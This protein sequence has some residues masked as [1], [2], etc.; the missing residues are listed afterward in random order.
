LRQKVL[1]ALANPPRIFYVPYTLAILNFL[2][3][4]LLF[5]VCIVVYTIIP[6]REIPMWL[7]LV[8]LGV[9]SLCHTILAFYSKKDQQISQLIFSNLKIIKN[10]IPRKLVV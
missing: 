9:L 3:W 10:R 4:F 8:F 2:V 5:V 1:K 7:P 6:P